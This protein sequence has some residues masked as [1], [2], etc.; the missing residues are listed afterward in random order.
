MTVA[1]LFARA[2]SNYKAIPGCELYDMERDARTY[3]GSCPVVAQPPCRA[4]GRLRTF[5]RTRGRTNATSGAWRLPCCG[6]LA[7]CWSTRQAAPFGLHRN[8]RHLEAVMPTA[9]R[10]WRHRR[11]GG[12]TRLRKTHGAG[13]QVFGR[14]LN[15]CSIG[16]GLE[17]KNQ[18]L[19]YSMN[20]PSI[21]LPRTVPFQTSLPYFAEFVSASNV[22]SSPELF[23]L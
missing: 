5:L 14:P 8:C 6:N 13:P 11:N 15:Q 7:V 1:V 16:A 23:A 10:H 17:L 19:G 21:S 4:W 9:A 22:I 18:G 20:V 2:D 3:D 12:A